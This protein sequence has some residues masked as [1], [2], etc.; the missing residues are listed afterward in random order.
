MQKKI[1]LIGV[2]MD[3]GASKRGVSMGPAAIRYGGVCEGIRALGYDLTDKGDL[4]CLTSGETS[5]KLRNYQQ[6][7][8]INQRLYLSTME[9]LQNGAL[10]IILGGDHSIAAGSISAVSKHYKQIGIIWIDAH[11]DWNDEFS[12]ESGN[13]HG[14]PFS[15]VCGWGPNLMVDFGQGPVFVDPKH[16]VQIGGRDIDTEERIRMKKAGVTVF[17]INVIDKLGM[18][19]VI[20]QAI[21]IACRDT[22]GFHLS[23]DIDA[24]TPEAAPGTGTVVHSGLTVREAFLAVETISETGK[25]LSMDMV[26]VNP[27]L[28]IR[29]KTGILAS[30][31][32]LSALGKVVF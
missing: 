1:E 3:L 19:E 16:C 14:M 11:G 25:M 32:I 9:S 4:L 7:V 31:L 21:N 30:E 22:V 6:V 27:I 5:E 12:T 20:E 24:I 17:P 8:D 13:M 10:P 23:F 15:A 2:Q 28:D 29:N 18:S 26:E